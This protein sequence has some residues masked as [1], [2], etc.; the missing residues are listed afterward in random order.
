[1]NILFDTLTSSFVRYPRSDDQPVVGLDSRYEVY[2]MVV[3]AEP[4]YEPSTHFLTSQDVPNHTAKTLTRQWQVNVFATPPVQEPDGPGNLPPQVIT[5]RQFRLWL[6]NND[7]MTAARAVINGLPAG[8]EKEK[9]LIEWDYAVAIERDHPLTI[10]V[11][12]ALGMTSPQIDQA[13]RE[14]SQL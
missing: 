9:A 6:A 1:M 3:N 8:P 10:L 7:L 2:A 12:T 11:A 5:P 4:E 14:A 13:F